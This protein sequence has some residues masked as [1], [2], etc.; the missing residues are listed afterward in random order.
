M[1][2]AARGDWEEFKPTSK[3]GKKAVVYVR[4]SRDDGKRKMS[5]QELRESVAVQ[6]ERGIEYANSK[7]WK[8]EVLDGDVNL[9]GFAFPSIRA[10][11]RR[12]LE[13]I[14]GNEVH[15]V[16]V[17]DL[18]RLVRDPLLLEE[19]ARLFARCGVSVEGWGEHINLNSIEGR[20]DA[21]IE[22]HSNRKQVAKQR[23][24]AMASKLSK[25]KAGRLALPPILGFHS[26][27]KGKVAA[28]PEEQEIV[29]RIFSEYIAG[30]G[31]LRIANMLTN[32]HVLAK[33]WN[34]TS[35]AEII[36]NPAYKGEI[37]YRE[38]TYASALYPAII[39]PEQWAEANARLTAHQSP[40]KGRTRAEHLL[41]GLLKCGSCGESYVV[42]TSA[43]RRRFYKCRNRHLFGRCESPSFAADVV[44][45]LILR[46]LAAPSLESVVEQANPPPALP[47]SRE[48]SLEAE[49]K[50]LKERQDV[51]DKEFAFGEIDKD[52]LETMSSALRERIE[53]VSQDLNGERA[54]LD[55]MKKASEAKKELRGIAAQSDADKRRIVR[56]VVKEIEV[57]ESVLIIRTRLDWTAD[58]ETISALEYHFQIVPKGKRTRLDESAVNIVGM[59]ADGSMYMSGFI[60]R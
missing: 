52:R 34:P 50:R 21:G 56:A 23:A 18:S 57:Q 32:E 51:I 58:G 39:P 4:V 24:A 60:A 22:S 54:K 10:D 48:P 28:A 11:L 26:A 33:E 53:K 46:T 6:K 20:S 8:Y 43:L 13:M 49:L 2:T 59:K 38:R 42:Y 17:R 41:A 5:E 31:T 30:N 16:I 12:L 40:A 47:P 9:S 7:G 45:S 35:I 3:S 25:A 15:T 44:E 55:A 27:G 29:R 37:R 36:R 1:T 19:L 14:S